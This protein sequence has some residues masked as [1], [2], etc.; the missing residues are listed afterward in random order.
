MLKL[1]AR[2][3]L[4]DR[5]KLLLVRLKLLPGACHQTLSFILASVRIQ[6]LMVS[7]CRLISC[8]MRHSWPVLHCDLQTL[9]VHLERNDLLESVCVVL[10]RR[11][12]DNASLL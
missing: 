1:L 12:H 7:P 6:W 10:M 9:C 5:L 8:L 2:L 11:M 3:K 4:L